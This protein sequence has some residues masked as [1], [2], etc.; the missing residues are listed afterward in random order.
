MSLTLIVFKI[1]LLISS[2]RVEL[3]VADDTGEGTFVCFDGV[4]A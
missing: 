2:Y 4:M 1:L 3:V